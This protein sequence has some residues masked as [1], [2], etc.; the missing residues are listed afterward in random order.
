[1]EGA[2][3]PFGVDNQLSKPLPPGIESTHEWLELPGVGPA[4]LG[5]YIGHALLNTG[6]MKAFDSGQ[7]RL[8]G[9]K[10]GDAVVHKSLGVQAA[11][12]A[13]RERPLLTV[14]AEPVVNQT[15][16][17]DPARLIYRAKEDH[18]AAITVACPFVED[19]AA[20]EKMS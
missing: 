10:R 20:Q 14:K 2:G 1:L 18:L 5:R 6:G 13:V 16:R 3:R 17:V 15:P 9:F 19:K 12:R 4:P 7:K 8:K 11:K